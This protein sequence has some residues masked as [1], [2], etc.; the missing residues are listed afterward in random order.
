M[1]RVR[2]TGKDSYL[3]CSRWPW[4]AWLSLYITRGGGERERSDIGDSP[5]QLCG[6]A[7]MGGSAGGVLVESLRRTNQRLGIIEGTLW[8]SSGQAD[9]TCRRPQDG[10][11][12]CEAA[13]RQYEAVG[14][15]KQ[16]PV[17]TCEFLAF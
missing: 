11:R 15:S 8:G 9:S 10:T 16:P 3:W 12:R 6:E 2:A 1:Q 7:R 13:G 17:S 14:K 5:T 4:L